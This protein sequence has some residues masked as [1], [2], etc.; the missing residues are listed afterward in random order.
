MASCPATSSGASTRSSACARAC[1]T[2]SPP[3]AVT[4]MVTP[5]RSPRR[6][7]RGAGDGGGP[8]TSGRLRRAAV[9]LM[10]AVRTSEADSSTGRTLHQAPPH[11]A[12][13]PLACD[14]L[15]PHLDPPQP[16]HR[17]QRRD[18]LGLPAPRPCLGLRRGE[19]VGATPGVRRPAAPPHQP[20]LCSPCSKDHH[21]FCRASDPALK[22]HCDCGCH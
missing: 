18:L 1:G 7:H 10:I 5:P 2:S 22:A 8:G 21:E 13:P 4:P 17:C 16:G 11:L 19:G 3:S 12:P 9:R 20:P 6:R 15:W 14:T